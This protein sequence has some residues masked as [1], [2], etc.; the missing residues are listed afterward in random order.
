MHRALVLHLLVCAA[1]FVARASGASADPNGIPVCTMA[2]D[3]QM[4]VIVPDGFGGAVIAWHDQRPGA[5]AGGICY[6]Q[7]VDA[8]G[9]PM[10][11]PDGVALST[12]GDATDPVIAPDGGGGAY[13]GFGGQGTAPRVQWINS[14]GAVQW[15]ADGVTLSTATTQARELAI[16]FDAGGQA[17]VLVAWRQDNGNSGSSDIFAQKLSFQGVLQWNPAGQPVEATANNEM[18]PA[19]IS[20]GA[21]GA[22]IAWVDGT[23][24][25]V[26]I[27]GLKS[28]SVGAWS[29]FPLST[30][31]NNMAPS[32]V[33]DGGGG[34]IVG[35]SG[36][37]S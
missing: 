17:D 19:L 28:N 25:G 29:R 37:G 24:G 21:G 1:T 5:P 18:L 14:G 12:S 8:S 35:W 30:T 36:G 7:R 32:I 9:T 15:G 22:V 10:W 11:T 13:I 2:G 6:A 34:T 26:K 23:S 33:P 31:A 4:P 16:A 3:Q 20:D 27:Q